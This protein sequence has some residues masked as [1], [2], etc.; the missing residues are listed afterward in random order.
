[1]QTASVT[2]LTNASATSA[3]GQWPGGRGSLDVVG[4]FGGASVTLQYLGP[5]G[6][7]WLDLKTM[8]PSTGAQTAV[9]LTAAGSIGFMLPPCPIRVAVSGGAPS[10]LFAQASRVPE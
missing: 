7:T 6:A 10:G 8:D 2:L 5:D 9:A 1:M 3:A 4:T